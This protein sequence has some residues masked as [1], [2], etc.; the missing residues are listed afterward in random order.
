MLKCPQPSDPHPL[1]QEANLIRKQYGIKVTGGRAPA[2]LEA[3]ADLSSRYNCSKRLMAN[4]ELNGWQDLTA[5]QRQAI[6]ALLERRELFATAPTGAFFS[7]YMLAVPRTSHSTACQQ[8]WSCPHGIACCCF[9]MAD[10]SSLERREL[11]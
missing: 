2:P 10:Y 8:Q 11:L 4:V 6:P 5:I 9:W 7:P 3:F 1:S